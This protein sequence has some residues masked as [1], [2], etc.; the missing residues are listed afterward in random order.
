LVVTR[1]YYQQICHA[2]PSLWISKHA[3]VMYVSRSFE[4]CRVFTRLHI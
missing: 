2:P 1:L 3:E 4:V